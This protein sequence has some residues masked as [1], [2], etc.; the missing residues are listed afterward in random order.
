M[1]Y[2]E[3]EILIR[4]TTISLPCVIPWQI[5]WNLWEMTC[6]KRLMNVLKIMLFAT[7]VSTHTVKQQ[8]KANEL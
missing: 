4:N 5:M 6:E 2:E 8:L 3:L 1:V 7:I